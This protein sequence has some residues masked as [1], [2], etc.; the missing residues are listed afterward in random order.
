MFQGESG[1][2]ANGVVAEAGSASEEK[3]SVVSLDGHSQSNGHG[4]KAAKCT[5]KPGAPFHEVGRAMATIMTDEVFTEIAYRAKNRHHILT[6]VDEFLDSV[7]VLPPG[8]WDPSIRIEPPPAVPSQVI[9]SFS[10]DLQFI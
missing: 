6:A 3:P 2:L 4:G 5:I 9:K 8:E 10:S 7:T 1:Q